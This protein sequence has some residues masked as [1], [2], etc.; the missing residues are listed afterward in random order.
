MIFNEIYSVYYNAVAK[1]IAQIISGERDEK[2][3]NQIVYDNAFGESMLTVLP[4]L[5]SEKWQLVRADMTTPIKHKPTMPPTL[6]QKQWLKAISLDP[7]IKLFDIEF[8]GLDD[9]EPLFTPADYIIYDK[10]GDGDP[11]EDEGYIE[12]FRTILS[13]LKE[14]QPLKIKTVNRKGNIISMS[15]MPQRLEYSEKDDKFRLINIGC[16]YGGTVNLARIVSCEKCA[17]GGFIQ[18]NSPVSE[19]RTVTLR[20]R[21]DRNA[22]ER[23]LLHFAH[24]EK[25]AE[26]VDKKHYTVHIKYDKDDETEMVIRIL[27]FGPMVEVIGPNDFRNLIIERL[28]RQKSCELK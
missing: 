11:F 13:A 3:L 8:N 25:R 16:R 17:V 18:Q 26:R 24:F 15:L 12:R 9:V 21:D 6:I 14:K 5:K 1:I 23:C 7:R 28:Q 19:K 10:Y 22:L 20:I 4:S 27:S 2:E